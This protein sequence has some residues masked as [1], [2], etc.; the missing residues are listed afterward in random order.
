[1]GDS[2]IASQSLVWGLNLTDH[3]D[4]PYTLA[5]AAHPA[6]ELLP[7]VPSVGLKL[8]DRFLCHNNS[9]QL[10]SVFR[11]EDVLAGPHNFKGPLDGYDFNFEVKY[12]FCQ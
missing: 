2:V 4:P 5:G 11:S 12:V 10:S 9:P 3:K 1:M 7:H 8:T 6:H